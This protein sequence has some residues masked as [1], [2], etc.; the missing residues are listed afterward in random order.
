MPRQERL[1]PETP[2]CS[3]MLQVEAK[4]R[5]RADKCE[6][7]NEEEKM[8]NENPTKK[9]NAPVFERRM[10]DVRCAVWR[11]ASADGTRHWYSVNLSRTYRQGE[12]LREAAGSLNGLPDI[13]LAI[14]GLQA[15]QE[16][17]ERESAGQR[18]TA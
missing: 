10:K 14:A 8:D 5:P 2:E 9:A 1:K 15:A 17:I 18:E 7:Q 12:E 13:A 16:F 4:R 3:K 11:N 6:R